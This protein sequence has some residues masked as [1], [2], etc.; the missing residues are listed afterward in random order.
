M[1]EDAKKGIWKLITKTVPEAILVTVL[2]YIGIVFGGGWIYKTLTASEKLDATY[3]QRV[4]NRFWLLFGFL[5]MALI[6]ICLVVY[7]V[8]KKKKKSPE[9][10]ETLPEGKIDAFIVEQDARSR[11]DKFNNINENVEKSYW[12]L[13][14]SLTSMVDRETMLKKMARKGMHIR[15]CMMDPNIAVEDLCLSSV[16][17]K[18]CNLSYLAEKIKNGQMKKEDIKSEFKNMKNCKDMLE[19]YHILINVLHFNDYYMTD[20]DYKNRIEDSYKNLKRIKNT[21]IKDYGHDSFELKVADSFMPMSLTIA[22]AEEL[23]GKMVVEFHLPFT[24][25]KVLFEISKQDNGELFKVFVDFY[26][27]VWERASES[28]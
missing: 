10:S 6:I 15:L 1:D 18:A 27:T 19:M 11:D 4:T 9:A 13:G 21:I 28:E 16:D 22:D 3:V 26:K 23:C 2:V 14:V 20:T 17:N 5:T 12:V 8:S 25:Y 7:A 24:Q